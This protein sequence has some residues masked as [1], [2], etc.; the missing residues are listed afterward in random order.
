MLSFC[1]FLACLVFLK[2]KASAFTVEHMGGGLTSV[3]MRDVISK[4]PPTPKPEGPIHN[5][6]QLMRSV[7]LHGDYFADVPIVLPSYTRLVLEGSMKPTLS[8]G[9]STTKMP[10]DNLCTAM[11]LGTGEMIGVEGGSFSC[12][13]W[14]STNRSTNTSTVTAIW[15]YNVL[16]GWIRSLTVKDCGMSAPAGPRPGYVS[17]NIRVQGGWGNSVEG[18][19]SC[20]SSNRGIW[21][22]TEK[23]MVWNG[24]WWNNEA[25]GIDFDSGTSKSVAY[26][27]V[28]ENNRRH[29]IFLEEG[30]SFNTIVNNTLINNSGAGVSEGS[31]DSGPTTDN[32]V[33]ANVLGPDCSN[34]PPTFDSAS[35]CY[36]Q[37]LA[38][39]GGS[40][41]HRTN[42]FLAVGNT[43]GGQTTGTHGSI[44]RGVFSL[45]EGF[46]G[47]SED[48]VSSNASIYFFNPN[49]DGPEQSQTPAL[50]PMN[51]V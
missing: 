21:A 11:I 7:R 18:V 27:N 40:Y 28:C 15:F 13:G 29:G 31:A 10:Q 45:N 5:G 26:N 42:D 32:V 41:E 36:G 17:G 2:C 51:M 9:C 46:G 24:H 8:L 43:L 19:D 30:A 6:T 50:G 25:D 38:V 48:R 35:A 4:L 20:C 3:V 49:S 12:T 16:G 14:T 34:A 1:S 37:P 44:Y 23:L 47:F 33:L 22:Q 39:G